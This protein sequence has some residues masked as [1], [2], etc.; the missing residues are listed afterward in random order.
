MG[1]LMLKKSSMQHPHFF[2]H[3]LLHVH[4]CFRGLKIGKTVIKTRWKKESIS[5]KKLE[6]KLSSIHLK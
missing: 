1:R 2:L 6:H 5:C 4:Q 3:L